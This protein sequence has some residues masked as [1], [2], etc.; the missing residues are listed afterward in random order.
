MTRK[1]RTM[2]T[3]N[4]LAYDLSTIIKKWAA[5]KAGTMSAEHVQAV[6]QQA[7]NTLAD[8][9]GGTELRWINEAVDEYQG[10]SIQLH[11]VWTN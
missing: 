5:E 2:R 9:F 10:V 3:D 11:E 8:E 4:A 1:E 7:V 6:V